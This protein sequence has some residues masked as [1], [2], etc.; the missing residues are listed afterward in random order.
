[1]IWRNSNTSAISLATLTPDSIKDPRPCT[2]DRSLCLIDFGLSYQSALVEDKGVD[3][4]VLERA[5]LSAHPNLA[6]MFA[7]ILKGYTQQTRDGK[8]ILKKLEEVR[9]RG[10]KKIAFG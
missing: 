7:D 2:R 3:L 9:M 4:Y 1:M 5:F 8:A 10:R 6:D